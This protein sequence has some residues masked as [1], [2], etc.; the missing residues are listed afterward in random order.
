MNPASR[1]DPDRSVPSTRIMVILIAIDLLLMIF[2]VVLWHLGND[3]LAAAAGVAAIALAT[4]TGRR[5]LAGPAAEVSP[6]TPPDD[7][8]P[9]SS[10]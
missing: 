4:D 9:G 7:Q 2:C 5:L 8:E 6:P 3:P 10:E 1:H